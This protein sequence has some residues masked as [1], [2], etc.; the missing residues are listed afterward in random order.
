MSYKAD[1][2]LIKVFLAIYESGSV[3]GAAEKI[4]LTQP[5]VSYSLARLR[6]LL[7]DPLFTRTREG[8][9]STF[10]ADQYYATF[11]DSILAIEQAIAAAQEFD[12]A[13]ANRTF[14]IA[15]SDLGEF[16]LLPII[17]EKFQQLAPN[18][19]MEVITIEVNQVESWLL[20][21]RID[22]AIGNLKFL[23]GT[24][25]SKK[26]FNE[27]YSCLLSTNHPRIKNNI[28]TEQFL[29]EK[30]ILISKST[31]HFI[32]DEYLRENSKSIDIALKIPHFSAL[33]GIIPKCDMIACLPTR[34]ANKFAESRDLISTPLPFDL[35]SFEVGLYWNNNIDEPSAHKWLCDVIYD[36]LSAL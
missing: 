17:M 21:G 15:L 1:L 19:S 2:G 20:R 32:I 18:C 29:T 34:V 28:N 26:L 23:K 13:L 25:E 6:K 11:R 7:N 14:R 33:P 22:A 9:Q 24:V 31:G 12:P 16:Y 30:H 5:S 3:S 35:P 36:S 4:H 10:I 8:M 27:N